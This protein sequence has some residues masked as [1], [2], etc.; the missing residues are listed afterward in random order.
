MQSFAD[1]CLKP[2]R[3]LE[4]KMASLIKEEDQEKIAAAALK[5]KEK[6][7]YREVPPTPEGM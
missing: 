4:E 3:G 7:Y 5:K 2:K 1:Q 6:A